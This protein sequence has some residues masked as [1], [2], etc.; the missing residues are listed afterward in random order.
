MKNKTI[1]IYDSTLRD[2]AQTKG[3]SFSLDDKLRILEILMRLE[4]IILRQAGLEQTQ[5]MTSYLKIFRKNLN[6]SSCFWHDE[7]KGKSAI[8]ILV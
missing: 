6:Q 1:K 7:K 2:G 5:L 8:M 4:L 3:V